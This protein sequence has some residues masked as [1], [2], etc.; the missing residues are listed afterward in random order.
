[1][2]ISLPQDRIEE[3]ENET[4][5]YTKKAAGAISIL[6]LLLSL[7]ACGNMLEE[8]KGNT[9]VEPVEN[10][11]AGILVKGEIKVQ[12]AVPSRAATSSRR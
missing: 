8:R 5:K 9:V 2:G 7:A 6:L 12:G 4:N 3:D 10:T 11:G 1:M